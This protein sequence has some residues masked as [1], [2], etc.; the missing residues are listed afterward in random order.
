M[1]TQSYLARGNLLFLFVVAFL[2]GIIAKNATGT[3]MRIGFDD[4]QTIIVHGALHDIDILEQ[5]LIKK[6]IPEAITDHDK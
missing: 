4:P 2:V 5:E 3:H 6:G 1:I